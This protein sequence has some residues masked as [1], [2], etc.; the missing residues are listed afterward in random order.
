MKVNDLSKIRNIGI[1]A[2]IDAGKTT[3]TERI[4]FYCGNIYKMGEVHEGTA[5]T[6]WMI[7]EQER[8]ITITSAAVTCYWKNYEINI[9]DTPGHVD[10]T[11]E[12]ERSLR[13]L[14]GAVCVFDGV[15][16]VEPQSETVWRQADRYKVPRIC[17]INKLDRVGAHFEEAVASIKERLH[18]NPV[19]IQLP[20]GKEGDFKGVIDLV[21]MKAFLWQD[22]Q[23]NKFSTEEIP[24]DLLDEALI[25][26]E[27]LIEK[28]SE[29]NDEM[30]EKILEG[31]EVTTE[32]IAKV[33][34]QATIDLKIT[35]TLCGSAFKNKGIQPLLDAVLAYLPS[36]SDIPE[37][38][39]LSA[40]DKEEQLVRKRSE[41]DPFS[42]LAFKIVSDPFVGVLTYMR[43]YSGQCETGEVLLNTRTGKRER[44]QKILHMQANTR[45]EVSVAKSGDILAFVGLK[46]VATGD[47]LCDQKFPIRFE[48]VMLPEPVIFVAIEP[49]SSQDAD[50]LQKSLE[51]LLLEDPTFHLKEEKETAQTLI[52]GMGELHLDIMVDRLKREFNVSVNVGSPQ[53][54]YR[55]SISQSVSL[56]EVFA[57]EVNNKKQFAQVKLRLEPSEDQGPLH[58]EN[59]AKETQIPAKFMKA[60]KK[61][62]ENAVNSGPIA[63]FPVVGV[64][65]VVLG[66][67]FDEAASDEIAFEIAAG[68]ALRAC[69]QQGQAIMLEPVM[70]LEVMAPD[71][72]LS[73]VITDLNARKARVNHIN[74]RGPLQVVDAF[75]PLSAMF[76]YSTDLRSLSQGRGSYSM[77][78]AKYEQVSKDTLAKIRGY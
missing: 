15:H 67:A 10:F 37:V 62:L 60:V 19:P 73:S 32:E 18:G 76:G 75:G 57:R 34:R 23:G 77:K 44:V 40:D 58:V 14:D 51:R 68:M 11:I 29:Y 55:E 9:I 66:G 43:I 42:A 53:V 45:E 33:L 38:H 6:D 72:Y 13:V 41:K 26:R 69:L 25:A 54:A 56:E 39:G 8:G 20:I 74:Q 71:E 47:T 78:F 21:G 22:D 36:P 65:A 59:L 50:K 2:H 28:L 61:G 4:L 35:P 64:K 5:T 48:S 16:G 7:Q 27:E 12:V 49:K 52:G 63:G 17:F 3:T 46:Q 1:A 31:K 70:A 30:L 24:A